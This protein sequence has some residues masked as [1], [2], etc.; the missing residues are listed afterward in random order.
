MLTSEHAKERA[1]DLVGRAIKAGADACDVVYSGSASTSV[2]MRLG[3]LEDVERSEGEEMALRVFVG[4]QSA[5]TS[6]SDLSV[7]ALSAMAERVV[8]MAREAPED[9]YAGLAPEDRLMRGAPLALDLDDG[10]EPSP[11]SL[12]ERA[13]AAEEAARA[14]KGVT[15]SEGGSASASRGVTA[16]ATSHGFAGSYTG[17]SHGLSASVLAGEGAAMQ[18]DYAYHSARHETDLEG[19][20]AIGRIAGERAVARLNPIK[21]KS[22]AVTVVYDP[23]VGNSLLGHLA[24]AITG[25]AIARKTSFLLEK[26]GERIFADGVNVIDDPLRVRGLRSRP[27]DA[28]GLPTSETRII[29]DGVLTGWLVD[30]TSGRQLGLPPTG[31]ATRG[32]AGTTN[33][34]LAPGSVSPAALMSDIKSGFYCT[35]LIGMGVNG[36]TGD[37]SRGASGFLIV[38]GEI[39]GPVAEVTIASNLKEMFANLIAANDLEFRYGTNVPTIRIDGMMLAGD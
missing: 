13:L 38:D 7:E 26:L 11:Q 10:N 2:Q 9:A 8:A 20:E 6:S 27:F 33:L 37:Y 19:A 23:R 5:S 30:S 16:L 28:E 15:N 12:R 18:R 36:L 14:V 17:S 22:G 25:N 31:H 35:E 4:K 3:A 39:A 29:A 34:H 1:A 21:M 32:S 24:G